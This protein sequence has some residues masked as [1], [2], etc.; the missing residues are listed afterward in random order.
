LF[1]ELVVQADLLA[2]EV[3]RVVPEVL[4]LRKLQNITSKLIIIFAK[5]AKFSPA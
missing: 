3:M 2:L 5:L 4:A 1:T